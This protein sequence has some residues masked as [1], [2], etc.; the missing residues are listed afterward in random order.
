MVGAEA[1][2]ANGTL[3]ATTGCGQNVYG[4]VQLYAKGVKGEE[5]TWIDN[6]EGSPTKGQSFTSSHHWQYFG[7]PVDSIIAKPT[8]SGATL[9]M[10]D[11]TYNGD[12]TQF[13]K[14]GIG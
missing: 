3:I 1:G 5:Q 11:E 6:I 10:Y 4:T 8:F 9:Y 7:I 12:N 13:Y 2:K 14:N